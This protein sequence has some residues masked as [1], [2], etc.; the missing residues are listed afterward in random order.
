MGVRQG[1]PHRSGT[2]GRSP[3]YFWGGEMTVPADEERGAWPVA[4]EIGQ[5]AGLRSSHSLE[6]QGPKVG[7]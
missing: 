1:G 4:P 7:R 2:D 3:R 6:Q 5:E